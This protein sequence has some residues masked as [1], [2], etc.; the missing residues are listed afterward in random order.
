VTVPAVWAADPEPK[1][2]QERVATP[3]PARSTVYAAA[4]R[5]AETHPEATLAEAFAAGY[6]MAQ[7]G[8]ITAPPVTADVAS[9]APE[10][11]P[12]RTII[13]ALL[14]FKDQVLADHPEEI[15]SG[16]WCSPDEVDQLITELTK[17]I[18]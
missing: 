15:E 4:E 14:H 18:E 7:G 13:A 2:F 16:E 10:G 8:M 3:P 17:E 12:R 6:L 5:W 11:K 1:Q 9:L